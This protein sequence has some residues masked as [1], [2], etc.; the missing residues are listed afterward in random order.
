MASILKT[1][2]PII[3][4]VP[5]SFWAKNTPTAEEK[6]SGPEVP[7]GIRMA[8]MRSFEKLSAADFNC[9]L[10]VNANSEYTFSN[11]LE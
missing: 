11:V 6:I 9:K 5:M 2:L 1:A 8:P 10:K 3:A 7:K 4:P